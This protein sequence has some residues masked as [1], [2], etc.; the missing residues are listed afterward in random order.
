MPII[1]TNESKNSNNTESANSQGS[2]NESSN[3]DE[4]SNEQSSNALNSS[5]TK[6]GEDT[7]IASSGSV[8]KEVDYKGEVALFNKGKMIKKLSKEEVAVLNI[9]APNVNKT[10][11]DLDNITTEY[12]TDAKFTKIGRAHV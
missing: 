10:S 11:I 6:S 12:A 2:S 8:S 9:L 5:K 3:D 1:G 7:T 4:S